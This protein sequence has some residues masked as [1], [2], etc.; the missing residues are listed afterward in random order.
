MQTI[1]EKSDDLQPVGTVFENT[2]LQRIVQKAEFLLALDRHVQ[3]ILPE[4]FAPHC[5]VMN[6][7]EYTLVLGVSSAAIATRIQ[8]LADDLLA[9][10]R[11]ES[12]YSRIL[13]IRCKVVPKIV[14]Y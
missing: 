12:R 13:N 8:F 1:H 9:S 14:R 6:M 2:S 10:L 4:S 5:Q 11:N 7:N 3:T